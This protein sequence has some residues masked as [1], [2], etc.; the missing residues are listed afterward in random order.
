MKTERR[1]RLDL[2][3]DDERFAIAAVGVAQQ[4]VGLF[5]T[6]LTL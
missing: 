3:E 1:T 6:R 2:D 4:A 5:V